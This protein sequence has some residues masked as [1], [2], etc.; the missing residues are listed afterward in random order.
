MRC[1][2]VVALLVLLA[3]CGSSGTSGRETGPAVGAHWLSFRHV[4]GVV[5]LTGPRR[6]GRLTV[7]AAG[8]LFLFRPG[9]ALSAF[10]RGPGGYQ[11]GPGDEPYIALSPAKPPRGADCSFGRDALYALSLGSLPAVVVVDA[12]GRARRFAELPGGETPKGIAFDEVGRFD[13]R[14]LVT[15]AAGSKTDIFILDCRGHVRTLTRSAPRLEGG[16]A[17]AP[18]TFGRYAGE[19]IAP[20]ENSGHVIAVDARGTAKTIADSGLPTGGDIGIESAGFV[21]P[22]FGR[23]DAAYLA[24]RGVPGNAHPGTD[25]ILMLRGTA[26]ARVGVAAGDLLIA[27][28]GGAQT[29]AVRCRKT[30]TVRHIADGPAVTHGEGHIVFGPAG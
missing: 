17:V 21:P 16:I 23:A 18:R 30:C 3:G 28:E 1:A 13:H 29:I 24:D 2:P 15:G 4:P 9:G 27:S 6:D 22:G 8:R 5:D 20:D 25:S 11:A 26:L 19:L 14:L 10:A 12:Q 7:T